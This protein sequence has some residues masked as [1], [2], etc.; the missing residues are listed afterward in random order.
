MIKYQSSALP[1]FPNY[2]FHL[3]HYITFVEQKV[4]IQLG[5]CQD[6]FFPM[7][8]HSSFHSRCVCFCLRPRQ[9]PSPSSSLVFQFWY[10]FLKVA[11]GDKNGH[12]HYVRESAPWTFSRRRSQRLAV[13]LLTSLWPSQSIQKRQAGE[14]GC[15]CGH[16]WLCTLPCC[17]T[18]CINQL[19]RERK[20]VWLNQWAVK[21]IMLRCRIVTI[22]LYCDRFM[23]RI[24]QDCWAWLNNELILSLLHL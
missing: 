24:Y 5:D 2:Q 17:L 9:P 11:C 20:R 4:M 8:S 3:P 6:I 13:V 22:R 23:N 12:A 10:S 21:P 14:K 15:A 16:Y 18:L 1:S 7:I 19:H